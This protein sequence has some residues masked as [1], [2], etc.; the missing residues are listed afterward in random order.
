MTPTKPPFQFGLG[1]LA[2]GRIAPIAIAGAILFAAML[3]YM[4]GY[5]TLSRD[6]GGTRYFASR[7]QCRLYYPAGEI[8]AKL[9][10]CEVNLMYP[11]TSRGCLYEFHSRHR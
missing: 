6:V 11:D 9:R 5:V 7:W 8:E 4:A 1:S 3:A 10:R 2:S